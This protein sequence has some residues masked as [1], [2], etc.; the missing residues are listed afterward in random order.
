MPANYFPNLLENTHVTI[1]YPFSVTSPRLICHLIGVTKT[2]NRSENP[3]TA[4]FLQIIDLSFPH[5]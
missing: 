3:C 4:D 2:Y 1:P 5:N